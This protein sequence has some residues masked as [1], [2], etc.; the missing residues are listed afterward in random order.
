VSA[1]GDEVALAA[2]ANRLRYAASADAE[3][4]AAIHAAYVEVAKTKLDRSM[5][6][7]Q[8]LVTAAGTIGTIY[9]GL[10]AL[11][12][13][14][15]ES[16]RQLPVRAIAPGVFLA[17]A[18]F[19]SVFRMAYVA[20]QRSDRFHQLPLAQSWR[21]QQRRLANF[22]AWIDRGSTQR[23]WAQR[24]AVVCVGAAV[25]LLPLPF[26]SLSKL[27]ATVAISAA[28]LG[29]LGYGFFELRLARRATPALLNES[30]EYD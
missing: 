4:R 12:Y 22:M 8:F 3:L 16:G 28:A 18:F 21:D 9:T 23:A 11:V 24:C 6:A 5:Q 17:L 20:T 2:R 30:A 14:A 10:L 1:S 29:V 25:A 13:S 19:L 26:V 15:S 27:G 7:T